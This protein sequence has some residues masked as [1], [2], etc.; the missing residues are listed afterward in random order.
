MLGRRC[1]PAADDFLVG[2]GWDI[3]HGVGFA[4]GVTCSSSATSARLAYGCSVQN[5]KVRG[6]RPVVGPKSTRLITVA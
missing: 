4:R 3:A 6:A 5:G 2:I 1:H